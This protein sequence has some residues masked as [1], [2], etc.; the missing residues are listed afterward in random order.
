MNRKINR[1]INR[2]I[3]W[4]LFAVA[5]IALAIALIAI[6]SAQETV[7]VRGTIDGIDGQTMRVTTRE[8]T[9]LSIKIAD[10]AAVAGVVQA[11]MADIKAGSYVGVAGLPQ[12]DGSQR[13]L[14]VLIF[15]E[16]MRGISEG[17][18]PWDLQPNST[19]TNATVAELVTQAGSD[20]LTLKYKDGE[21]VIAV[22]PGTPIVTYV[23]GDKSE[24]KPGAKIFIAGAAKQPDG[25][26]VAA[27]IGVG[28]GL[29]PP[30]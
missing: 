2:N 18:R 24:L 27:R 26:L 4:S 15:P 12:A 29:T 13:A 11:S 3:K 1:K 9:K 21:K 14:E 23:P 17:F 7:R 8:G 5:A 25:S 28:R 16:A 19:M 30:M 10:N 20:T 22:P 6:A